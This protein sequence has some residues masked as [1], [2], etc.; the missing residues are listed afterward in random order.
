MQN[1]TWFTW[2]TNE[3]LLSLEFNQSH[4]FKIDAM[5]IN[6]LSID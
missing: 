1:K 4:L 5:K 3:I 2:H 6:P